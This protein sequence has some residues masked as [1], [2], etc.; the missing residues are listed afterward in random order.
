MSNP[1]PAST[2]FVDEPMTTQIPSSV[3][4]VESVTKSFGATVALN[5]AS[6]EAARGEVHALLGENGA[7]KSTMVKMLSGLIQPDQGTIRIHGQAVA[8]HSPAQAHALGIRTAFQEISLTPDLSVARNLLLSIEPMWLGLLVDRRE[9]ARRV[10][11]LLAELELEDVDP[12]A[13][14]R[15]LD[16]PVRQKIEIA[17]AISRDP[18]IL[19]LDEPTSALSGRDVEWLERRVAKL[20]AAGTTVILITHRMQEVR[21]FC[22]RLSVLRNGKQVGAFAVSAISDDEVFRLVVG[23]SVATAFPP[24]EPVP[25]PR[26]PA[27]VLA[28]KG[29]SV[30]PRM[31]DVSFDLWPG[32][33][34]GVAGLQGMG[35]L[36]LFLALFGMSPLDAG[37]I[38]VDGCPRILA[39]PRDAVKAH[40]GI[41]LVPEERK[42]EA[43]ALKLSGRENVSLPVIDRFAR[44]GWIDVN[45]EWRE[46]DRILG[47]V[48]V[49][50]R[51]LYRSCSTFSGGNQQKIALAKWL[52]AESRVLLL[53]DPTRGVDIGTKQEIYRLMREFT[54]AGGSI[55]FYSTDAAEIVNLSDRVMVMYRGRGRGRSFATIRSARTRSCRRRSEAQSR[56]RPRNWGAWHDRRNVLRFS[57][58]ALAVRHAA[59]PGADSRSG[60]L[61]GHIWRPQRRHADAV[62]LL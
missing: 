5:G 25:V 39:S 53:F 13:D 23:R 50:P 38:E 41:S 59:P 45:A 16:L 4:S 47:R 19:L 58:L 62:R 33:V 52:L 49:H 1:A 20:R 2:C 9:S 7:G 60:R 11:A 10:A 27:P 51:A 15:D 21:V 29:L 8:L 48:N 14:V 28:G 57:R 34:L 36:D 26:G 61:R 46:V 40:I 35:Q 24:R 55:L 31:E 12:D 56:S 42:T 37:Q 6:F 43:L 3:I 44:F 30:A 22:D 32:E 17:R 18:R 54:R